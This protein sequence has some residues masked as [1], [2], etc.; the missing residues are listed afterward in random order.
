MWD[1]IGDFIAMGGYA[2]YVWGAYGVFALALLIEAVQL[3]ARRRRLGR[4]LHRRS[5]AAAA[6]SGPEQNLSGE[7]AGS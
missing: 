3:G 2:A 4:I 7:H 1:G 6:V 5:R